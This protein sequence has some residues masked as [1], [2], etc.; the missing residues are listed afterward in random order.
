M[1]DIFQEFR[2]AVRVILRNGTLTV[3]IF[4]SLSLGIG[5]TASIFSLV[6]SFLVRPLP[7]PETDRVVRIT[8]VTESNPVCPLSYPDFDDLRQRARSFDGITFTRDDGAGLITSPGARPR[9]TLGT[10][11]TGDFFATLQLRPALGRSFT[12]EEDR[13]P[14]RDTVAIISYNLWQNAYGGSPD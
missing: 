1:R 9:I 11:V 13:V 5:A 12:S 8:C 14:G 6:D 7:V 3:A 2:H 10:I 4:V